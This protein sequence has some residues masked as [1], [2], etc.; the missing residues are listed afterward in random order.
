M[1]FRKKNYEVMVLEPGKIYVVAL[2]D[3]GQVIRNTTIKYLR[4]LELRHGFKLVLMD[5]RHFEFITVLK[6]RRDA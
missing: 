6:G 2:K 1:F 4:G 5:K 3:T